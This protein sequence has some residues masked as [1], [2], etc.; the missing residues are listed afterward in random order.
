MICRATVTPTNDK[1]ILDIRTFHKKWPTR[2]GVALFTDEVGFLLNLIE[3][4]NKNEI[5]GT[6]KNG[7][8]VLRVSKALKDGLKITVEKKGVKEKRF[9]TSISLD[10][11]SK[12]ALILNLNQLYE[13][14]KEYEDAFETEYKE[15]EKESAFIPF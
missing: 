14:M 3:N 15:E 9:S 2:E 12:E 11:A 5:K 4:K 8:R 6:T 10:S 7:G 1:C 13:A